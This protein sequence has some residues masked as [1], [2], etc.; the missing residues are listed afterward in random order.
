MKIEEIT[1]ITDTHLES[2]ELSGID[3]EEHQTE[4]ILLENIKE[5]LDSYAS[6]PSFRVNVP[7]VSNSSATF[8]YNFFTPNEREIIN[9]ESKILDVSVSREDEILFQE[10]ND[11]KPRYVSIQFT[12]PKKFEGIISDLR[13]SK[14]VSENL[15]KIVIEGGVSNQ[16]FVSFEI[17]D[18][19]KEKSLYSILDGCI[20]ITNT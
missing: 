17:V 15:D 13:N 2:Q 10:R 5:V 11:R 12:P 18:S 8:V 14:I 1:D 7:E 3:L 6:V 19:G 20:F 9:N 4:D 16:D